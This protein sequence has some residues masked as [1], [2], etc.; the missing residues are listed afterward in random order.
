MQTVTVITSRRT[1]ARISS[2]LLLSGT[3]SCLSNNLVEELPR[4]DVSR[5]GQMSMRSASTSTSARLNSWGSS[6]QPWEWLGSRGFK[7]GGHLSHFGKEA[8]EGRGE[9]LSPSPS[10]SKESKT[11]R[12]NLIQPEGRLVQIHACLPNGFL[13]G[14]RTVEGSVIAVGDLWLRWKP[15]LFLEITMESLVLVDIV[16]PVPDILVIGCGDRMR[17]VD[18]GLMRCL[19]DRFL[20]VEA[21][22]TNNAVSTFNILNAEGRSVVGAFLV[23]GS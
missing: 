19:E 3:S 23:S 18:P 4:D 17:Q 20:G 2:G 9:G 13:I 16:K 12:F 6:L 14:D 5:L 10:P 7:S 8:D 1:L 15:R 22:D 21:L 11:D